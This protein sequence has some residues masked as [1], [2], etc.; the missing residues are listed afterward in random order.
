MTNANKPADEIIEL[1][2]IVD[3]DTGLGETEVRAAE[4]MSDT[5]ALDQE[6]DN[7]LREVSGQKL[8]TGRFEGSASEPVLAK[9]DASSAKTPASGL[10][11]ELE[12]L[13]ESF[14]NAPA[15]AESNAL[16]Q[17]LGTE[18]SMAAAPDRAASDVTAE[19]GE[20]PVAREQAQDQAEE[21]IIELT[22][23]VDEAEAAET[24]TSQESLP[25]DL[26]G[27]AT[28]PDE[29][30][31]L[32]FAAED[33]VEVFDP[34]QSLTPQFVEKT[35]IA[36]SKDPGSEEVISS[37][38]SNK[39]MDTLTDPQDT[40]SFLEFQAS[41]D[42]LSTRLD[43]LEER[44]DKP[45][46]PSSEEILAALPTTAAELPFVAD[47]QE[48][49]VN[50]VSANLNAV[51]TQEDE[52]LR[53]EVGAMHF[54]LTSLEA[55][56]MPGPMSSQEI[57]ANLPL[58]PEQI[59]VLDTLRQNIL[60][61][62]ETRLAKLDSASTLD[63]LRE[64]IN[65]E[66]MAIK[67][68]LAELEQAK[69]IDTLRQELDTYGQRLDALTTRTVSTEDILAALPADP[70]QIPAL[71]RVHEYMQAEFS[72]LAVDLA[73]LQARPSPEL[74]EEELLNLRELVQG[75]N[76]E[77]QALRDALVQKESALAALHQRVQELEDAVTQETTQLTEKIKN[78]V[79]AS[80]Q[81]QIPAVAAQVIREE[82]TTL[83]QE[84]ES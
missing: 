56:P 14:K 38:I 36:S 55:R 31:P 45:K 30:N 48:T 22:E 27:T 11:E 15:P 43:K 34:P 6:L 79:L 13:Y 26:V 53:Q 7:L 66:Q 67:E 59:P 41:W 20:D 16:D 2:E 60:T 4:D 49:I 75:Q 50:A 78:D 65:A 46:E 52:S 63:A 8:T 83:V 70:S 77:L 18:E 19:R 35:E 51:S 71:D 54:R 80:V 32:D 10:D 37:L 5:S 25:V 29:E 1:T 39:D 84:L 61:E 82:I 68:Q 81:K 73:E 58:E 33:R 28:E 23:I 44:I 47:L 24:S 42:A 64:D 62:L 9:N 17:L 72:S 40:S 76:E 12:D 57:I 74:L 3:E 69:A 21:V